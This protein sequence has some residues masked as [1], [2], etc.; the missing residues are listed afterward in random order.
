MTQQSEESE[1]EQESPNPDPR[2]SLASSPER[3]RMKSRKRKRLW[4]HQSSEE[5]HV[6]NRCG[7]E[8]TSSSL[9]TGEEEVTSTFIRLL[10]TTA[11]GRILQEINIVSHSIS[12]SIEPTQ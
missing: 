8:L 10:S 7:N 1:G 11:V 4:V 5:D 6:W 9:G 12:I 2:P 3:E